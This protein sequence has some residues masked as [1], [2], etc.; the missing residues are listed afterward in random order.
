MDE[1]NFDTKLKAGKYAVEIDRKQ[2]YGYFEH[3]ELGDAAGG[4]LWFEIMPKSESS[5]EI[6][7]RLI[8]YDGMAVL[9][10]VI[11]EELRKAGFVAD[12][13]FE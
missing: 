12:E 5:L 9:P 8:D 11:I 3:D 4:G 10:R 1:F 6:K 2:L 7:L 13:D